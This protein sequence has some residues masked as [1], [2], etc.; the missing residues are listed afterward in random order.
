MEEIELIYND[1]GTIT[2]HNGPD[3][4]GFLDLTQDQIDI[5]IQENKLQS[6]RLQRNSLLQETDWSQL[7]DVPK[8]L[9]DKYKEYRQY[10]RDI[11]IT[12]SSL[13]DVVF[14]VKPE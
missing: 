14:P 8:V 11:T 1:E 2:G 4:S 12:F 3:L 13:E 5:K 6:L 9:K 7:E 10:L